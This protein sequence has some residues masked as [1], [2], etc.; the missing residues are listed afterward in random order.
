MRSVYLETSIVSYLAARPS[1]DI[2][3][4]GQQQIT[5]AWWETQREN[6]TTYIS[7][8]VIQEA[9]NG[10]VEAARARLAILESLE[11]VEISSDALHLASQLI[12]GAALPPKAVADALHI[13]IAVTSGIDFLL[14][15]NCKHIAN[16]AMRGRIERICSGAGYQ[17]SIICT[18]TELMESKHG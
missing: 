6:F 13:A 4:A 16:A 3:A 14:T 7:E 2:V 18:P 15:W 17:P 5:H 9:R 8:L 12:T 10:D 11:V 1:R